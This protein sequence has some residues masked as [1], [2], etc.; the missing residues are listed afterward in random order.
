MKKF[1]VFLFIIN[2]FSE[3]MTETD[4]DMEKVSQE[5]QKKYIEEFKE[6][7]A[8]YLKSKNL[9]KNESAIVDKEQFAKIF[10]D[11][12]SGGAPVQPEYKSLMNS[13]TK[14]FVDEAFPKGKET[15]KGS[16]IDAF[17]T[18]EK[19]MEGFDNFESRKKGGSTSSSEENKTTDKKDSSKSDL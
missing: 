7:V 2:L 6:I 4:E 17:F 8:N 19:I 11:I 3:I 12:M 14:K 18:Y 5:F 1:F 13:M 15:I 10:R 16:E 9:Y